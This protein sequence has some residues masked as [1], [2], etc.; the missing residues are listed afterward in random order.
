MQEGEDAEPGA[1]ATATDCGAVEALLLAIEKLSDQSDDSCMCTAADTLIKLCQAERSAQDRVHAAD[2]MKRVTDLVQRACS[3]NNHAHTYLLRLLHTCC[4]GNEPNKVALIDAHGHALI[5]R[6]IHRSMMSNSDTLR[7]A[8][9][10]TRSLVTADDASRAASATFQHGRAMFDLNPSVQGTLLN[11][12]AKITEQKDAKMRQSVAAVAAALKASA[13]ND[14]VCTRLA[15]D[16]GVQVMLDVLHSWRGDSQVVRSALA[17]LKQ[18][19]ASDENK[20]RIRNGTSFTCFVPHR[21][22]LMRIGVIWRE[23]PHATA[24]CPCPC[25]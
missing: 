12:L 11:A 20:S 8:C 6:S 5:Q 16:G 15:E 21:L 14:E 4:K 7:A 18:L 1:A 3:E 10:C 2:G 19:A 9:A 24:G 13:V 25:R 22:L 23:K 17:L